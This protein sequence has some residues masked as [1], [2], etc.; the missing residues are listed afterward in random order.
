MAA[1][2]ISSARPGARSES[3]ENYIRRLEQLETIAKG[4]IGVKQAYAI[5]AGREI[6]VMVEPISTWEPS[7]SMKLKVPM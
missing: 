6:R 1:D 3:L 5:Q 4:H 2:T 7:I